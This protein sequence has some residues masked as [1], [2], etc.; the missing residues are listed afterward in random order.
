[1]KLASN[2]KAYSLAKIIFSFNFLVFL[3]FPLTDLQ[4]DETSAATPVSQTT[5]SAEPAPATAPA[6]VIENPIV[7]AEAPVSPSPAVPAV[8]PVAMEEETNLSFRPKVQITQNGEEM[9]LVITYPHPMDFSSQNYI[10]YIRLESL[11]GEFLSLANSTPE[12]T[13]PV[14]RFS[15]NPKLVSS[16]QIRLVALSTKAGLIKSVHKLEATPQEDAPSAPTATDD[17]AKTSKE[18]KSKKKFLGL[19]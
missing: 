16:N 1:M 4:A 18:H 5:D 3:A 9:A 2:T 8:S 7:A 6:P 11:D 10:E 14:A 17:S 13:E 15:I 12:W 19:F